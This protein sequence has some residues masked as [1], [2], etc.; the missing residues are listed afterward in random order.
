MGNQNFPRKKLAKDVGNVLVATAKRKLEL[1]IR[2]GCIE[3]QRLSKEF[4]PRGGQKG[5]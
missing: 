1:E 2:K 4:P 5:K 3:G